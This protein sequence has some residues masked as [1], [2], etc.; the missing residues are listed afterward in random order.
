MDVVKVNDVFS[1]VESMLYELYKDDPNHENTVFVL[2]YHLLKTFK[3]IR[4]AKPNCKIIIFQ[5]EQF[6][7]GT[8]WAQSKISNLLREADEIW[9]Y[10]EDNVNWLRGNF[11]VSV[12]LHPIIFTNSLKK[13]PT[14]NEMSNDDLDIDLLFYGMLH[15]KR[16]RLLSAV[17][18][19]MRGHGKVIDLCGVFGDE[20]DGYIKRAKII[21][22]VHFANHHR[23]EQVRM[24]YPVINGRCVVSEVS[25]KS[26]MEKS[27][28]EV[29]YEDMA[30][31]IVTLIN[32]GKWRDQASHCSETF[33]NITSKYTQLPLDVKRAVS[34][35]LFPW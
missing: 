7:N 28:I 34:Q 6:Y 14:V 16:A 30:G 19:A 33:R 8:P 32:N 11:G 22:N 26:Y 12:K 23:Q 31:A 29:P 21:C 5:L 17:Q 1:H 9:D 24:F 3:S 2:G 4:D 27:I 15:E 20:L 10:D 13:M 18:S 25:P 35:P